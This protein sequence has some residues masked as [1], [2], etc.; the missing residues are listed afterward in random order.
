M[1]F[2]IAVITPGRLD[3]LNL[4]KPSFIDQ[5]EKPEDIE[6]IF[7]DNA[8]T[9]GL[10]LSAWLDDLNV[11]KKKFIKNKT[12]QGVTRFWH[13]IIQLA[14]YDWIILL[15]DDIL[16]TP[17]WDVRLAKLIEKNP[18]FGIFLICQRQMFSGF[19]INKDFYRKVGPFRQEY[20]GGGRE[21]EDFFMTTA[22][23]LGCKNTEEMISKHVY[24]VY[25]LREIDKEKYLFLHFQIVGSKYRKEWDH[26]INIPIFEKYWEYLGMHEKGEKPKGAFES[27]KR[28]AFYK[29]RLPLEKMFPLWPEEDKEE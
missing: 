7:M 17:A 18:S 3:S 13:R 21:D 2:T 25:R 14:T 15:N 16:F 26:R 29:P 28:N 19:A 27:S 24:T 11:G 9:F 5:T 23:K 10:D 22:L 4:L 1:K 12:S 20:T 6:F 8:N